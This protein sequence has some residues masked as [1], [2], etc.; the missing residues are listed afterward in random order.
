MSEF[1]SYFK[2]GIDHIIARD[3]ADHLLFLIVL[4]FSVRAPL[5]RMRL[6]R[7][8]TGFTVGHA[9]SM[10]LSQFYPSPADVRIIEILIAGT[11]AIGALSNLISRADT[12]AFWPEIII[13][14]IFGVIHGL[15]F[16]STISGMF[17]SKQDVLIPLLGFNAGV[18]IAQ[19]FV[20]GILYLILYFWNLLFKKWLSTTVMVINIL[21]LT[22]ALYWVA[23][24]MNLL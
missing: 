2:L 11:I 19:I 22:V 16:S 21:I 14:S 20:V 23:E 24:R 1:I 12:Y 5:H 9:V 10:A 17:K 7:L 15:G 6:V 3:A 13:I 4:V 18:E 8:V